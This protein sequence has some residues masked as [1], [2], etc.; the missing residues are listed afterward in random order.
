MR[1][2]QVFHLSPNPWIALNLGVRFHEDTVEPGIFGAVEGTRLIVELEIANDP[3]V[4]WIGGAYIAAT[5][6]KPFRL[7]EIN[8]LG[9]I[10]GNDGV[11]LVHFGHTIQLD[12][13]KDGHTV[14]SQSSRKRDGFR[15]A[16]AMSVED[17][18]GL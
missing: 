5:M 10:G 4:V 15:S 18:A 17:D 7:I 1:A 3:R 2:D 9:H 6:E 11:I 14:S 13:E 16:P 12:S 8:G